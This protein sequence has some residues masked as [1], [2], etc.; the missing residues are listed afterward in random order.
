MNSSIKNHYG[1]RHGNLLLCLL[2]LATARLVVVMYDTI[3][4]PDLI[5]GIN[6]LSVLI[7]A[8][9]LFGYVIVHI[10]KRMDFRKENGIPE[11]C[12]S[13]R[14]I[15]KITSIYDDKPVVL[16]GANRKITVSA[17]KAV[18]GGHQRVGWA[19]IVQVFNGWPIKSPVPCVDPGPGVGCFL[20]LVKGKNGL[21]LEEFEDP[22]IIDGENINKCQI[23]QGNPA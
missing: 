13:S 3:E 14:F 6:F 21:S 7:I 22:V 16:S 17:Y 11:T 1:L 12:L 23:A 2:L 15:Y 18:K 5:G 9:V 19:K 8:L 10:E 20:H 4:E